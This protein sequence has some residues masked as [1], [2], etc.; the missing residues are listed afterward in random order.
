MRIV[1]CRCLLLFSSN[2][3]NADKAGVAYL[4]SNNVAA[5]V[6][7]NI[8][9]HLELRTGTALGLALNSILTRTFARGSNTKL[10]RRSVL[11]S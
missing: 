3:N 1:R 2:W 8:G 5:N 4:N 11:V 9:T 7:T 6:N 10:N